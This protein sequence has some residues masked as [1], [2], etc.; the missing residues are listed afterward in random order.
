MNKTEKELIFETLVDGLGAL[1]GGDKKMLERLNKWA[2]EQRKIFYSDGRS[3]SWTLERREKHGQAVRSAT[4]PYCY[5]MEIFNVPVYGGAQLG[6]IYIDTPAEVATLMGIKIHSFRCQ[7]STGRG[8]ISRDINYLTTVTEKIP[9][10]PS[11]KFT[12]VNVAKRESLVDVLTRIGIL[13]K[14]QQRVLA[15]T[16]RGAS[17]GRPS[18]KDSPGELPL[19][20]GY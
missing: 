14:G 9:R 1:A 8:R 7:M 13:D 18:T 17:R 15:N 19:P 10:V 4:N 11:I 20:G 12:A 6:T 2:D 3:T 5:R 16:P